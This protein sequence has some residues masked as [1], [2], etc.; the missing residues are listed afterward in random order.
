MTWT[1]LEGRYPQSRKV[2]PLSDAAFRTDVEGMCWCNEEGTDGRILEEELA[3]IGDGKRKAKHAA[4]LVRRGRWHA[5]G[6]PACDSDRCPHD[7][8]HPD[9][10]V[11][12]DFHGYN[13]TKAEVE[14][15]REAK[16]DRQRRYMEKARHAKRRTDDASQDATVDAPRDGPNDGS[17]DVTPPRPA[18][19]RPEGSGGGAPPSTSGEH[20]GRDDTRPPPAEPDAVRQH[21]AAARAALGTTSR[22]H[23]T[24]VTGALDRLRAATTEPEGE[25]TT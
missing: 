4:E 20:G 24:A 13:P 2:R 16:R 15:E 7:G 6:D 9:G 3:L 11:I 25:T 18:P 1:R 12:H 21:A 17:A 23:H 5:A 8:Q 10:W 19:P 14:R 22:T